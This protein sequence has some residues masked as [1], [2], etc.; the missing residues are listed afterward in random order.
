MVIDHFTRKNVPV[1]CVHDS[2]V[3]HP[4]YADELDCT[5]REA[6]PRALH[7]NHVGIDVTPRLKRKTIDV[8]KMGLVE[9]TDG[10]KYE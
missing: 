8:L 3:I 9:Y 6:L 2:F 1:L 7:S 5:M 10:K 4:A